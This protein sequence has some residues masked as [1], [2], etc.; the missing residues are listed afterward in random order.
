MR[1]K[2]ECGSTMDAVIQT[3]QY[4]PLGSVITAGGL[5]VAL[6]VI[7]PRILSDQKKK[8]PKHLR[9]VPGGLL[10]F[11]FLFLFI[12]LLVF[13]CFMILGGKRLCLFVVKL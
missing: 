5:V 11:P 3:I 6:G 4:W 7:S 12:F 1:E 8:S 2:K 13:V 9:T 10:V